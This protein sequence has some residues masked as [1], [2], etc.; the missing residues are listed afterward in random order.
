MADVTEPLVYRWTWSLKSPPEALWPLVSN[1]DRFNRDCGFPAVVTVPAKPGQS[2][3]ITNGRRVRA[4]V[5]GITVEWDERPFEWEENRRFSVRRS[6]HSGPVL[7]MM[8]SCTLE[9]SASGGTELLYEMVIVPKGIIGRL[10]T[11]YGVGHRSRALFERTFRL[12]DGYA[13]KGILRSNLVTAPA[14]AP[15]GEARL[16]AGEKALAES[17]GQRRALV[18]KLS[19]YLRTADDLSVSRIRCFAVADAWKENRIETLSLFLHATRLGVLDFSWDIVCPHCRGAKQSG[20]SLIEL[21]NVGRCDTCDIDFSV[22]FDRSV[23]LTFNPNP[24]VRA[25]TRADYCIGGPQVTPH[26]VAQ[27]DIGPGASRVF[28]I[29]L[30]AGRYRARIPGSSRIYPFLIDPHGAAAGLMQLSL[31]PRPEFPLAEKSMLTLS[32]EGSSGLLAII[33]HTA[34]SDQ[35]TSAAEVTS[36]QSFRDLFSREVLRPGEQISVGSMTIVFT[37]LKG[38]TAMY[39]QIGDAPAFG[40]VLGHFDVLKAAVAENDGSIVKTMGDAVMAVFRN[41]GK[42]LNAMITARDRL[43]ALPTPAGD[44]FPL[45]LKAGLHFGPCLAITQNDHLDYFGTAVNL[46]A[47]LCSQSTG[48]DFVMSEPMAADPSVASLLG[49]Q[50]D[51][52][53]TRNE[54]VKINGFGNE[55]VAIRRLLFSA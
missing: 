42:G 6:Y 21:K 36:L 46:A 25:V 41:P 14:L 48:N 28:P 54:E 45:R 23:E 17:G 18:G 1:T 30:A 22:D 52:F 11:R 38:S 40:R 29:D 16:L 49:A 50:P 34:W 10:A 9:P 3:V 24:S 53:V 31:A 19:D 27:A 2:G 39:R 12:Y 13:Q 47:R 20:N 32:N 37:D 33:E 8:S 26:I 5:S 55:I 4:V 51:R 7:S 44:A 35:A 43:A 15:G